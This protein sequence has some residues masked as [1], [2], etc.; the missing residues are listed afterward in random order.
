MIIVRNF[1]SGGIHENVL[2]GDGHF[3]RSH[4]EHLTYDRVFGNTFLTEK[5]YTG[6]S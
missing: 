1:P 6:S 3:A 2:S 5:T 4:S